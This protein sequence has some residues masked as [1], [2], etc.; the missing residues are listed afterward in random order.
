MTLSE[1]FEKYTE[2]KF[3]RTSWPLPQFLKTTDYQEI[4]DYFK[5]RSASYEWLKGLHAWGNNESRGMGFVILDLMLNDAEANDWINF[6]DLKTPEEF[7]KT[8]EDKLTTVT[9]N[10]EGL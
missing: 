8:I 6:D 10:L 4:Y 7:V 2:G 3:F 1:I 9:I 5:N